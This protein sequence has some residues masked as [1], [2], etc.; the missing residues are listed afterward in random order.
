MFLRIGRKLINTD[1]MADAD[2]FE[3]GEE[4]TPYR[5]GT[6]GTRTVVI[7]TTATETAEDGKLGPRRI[8]LSGEDADLF[9]ESLPVYAPVLQGS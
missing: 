5:E 1:N 7:T 2:V 6:A 8:I 4:M 9:I 3:V